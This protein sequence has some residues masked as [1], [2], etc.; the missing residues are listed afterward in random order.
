MI[1][2]LWELILTDKI[3]NYFKYF[4]LPSAVLKLSRLK[5][6]TLVT[7]FS[8]LF[9]TQSEQNANFLDSLGLNFGIAGNTEFDYVIVGAGTSGC[10][11]A[12]RLAKD[13]GV[14][15]AVVEAGGFYQIE[16]GNRSVVPGCSVF[17]FEI[18]SA[19]VTD[20]G[21]LSTPETAE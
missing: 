11:I 16:N 5:M 3:I 14:K 12:A 2:E 21:I 15:I 8:M 20:C 18:L 6:S 1:N 10:T 4:P 9:V 19:P 7:L 17:N 13:T